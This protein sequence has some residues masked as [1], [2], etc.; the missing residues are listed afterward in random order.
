MKADNN[1]YN[2][3]LDLE[4]NPELNPILFLRPASGFVLKQIILHLNRSG[5]ASTTLFKCTLKISIISPSFNLIKNVPLCQMISHNYFSNRGV[6]CT[7]W[8]I[9]DPPLWGMGILHNVLG[10]KKLEMKKE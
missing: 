5:S 8:N 10:G 7:S 1:F 4:P 2:N 6:H 9:G 3:F